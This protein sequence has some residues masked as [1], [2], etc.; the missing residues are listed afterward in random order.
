MAIA[1]AF[2]ID[3]DG[4]LSLPGAWGPIALVAAN[5]FVVCF[6]ASWGPLVWVLLGEIFPNNIRG[7]AL[8]IAAGAQ[9]IANFL[10]TI[11]FPPLADFSLFFTYGMYAA[12]ALLSFIFVLFR[13]PETKGMQ[14]EDAES[15]FTKA[16]EQ[17][18]ARQAAR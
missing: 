17:R 18:Q 15:V 13:I 6:G 9:W 3:K 2:A 7:K 10:V 1:F 4:S 8:G 11:T 12:F 5:L 14:L 16:R